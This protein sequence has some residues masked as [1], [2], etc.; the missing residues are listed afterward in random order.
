MGRARR[1]VRQQGK[2]NGGVKGEGCRGRGGKC[3]EGEK[4]EA[5]WLGTR[6]FHLNFW[7]I[8]VGSLT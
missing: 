3:P 4:N 1:R 2:K 8:L 7:D 5:K 6:C